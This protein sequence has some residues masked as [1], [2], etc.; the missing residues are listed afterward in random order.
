MQAKQGRLHILGEMNKVINQPSADLKPHAP[1]MVEIIIDKS[2]IGAVIGPGGK[3]IQEMQKD[4][5]TTITIEENDK[6]EGCVQIVAHNAE[7]MA[8]AL[9]RIRLIAFPPQVEVDGIYEGK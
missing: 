6:G 4:T 9:R 1:R 5:H 2:F 3:I 8:A 7:D